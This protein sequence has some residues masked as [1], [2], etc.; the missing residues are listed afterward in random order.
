[1]KINE[2]MHMD[3]WDLLASSLPMDGVTVKILNNPEGT[4]TNQSEGTSDRSE[5]GWP[6]DYCVFISQC[7]GSPSGW[8]P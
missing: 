7:L 5:L 8:L 6:L 3:D 4:G 1:M 2:F